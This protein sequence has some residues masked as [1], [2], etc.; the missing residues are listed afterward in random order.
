MV[1]AGPLLPLLQTK[2]CAGLGL[3][4]TK[5]ELDLDFKFGGAFISASDE[6]VK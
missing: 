5:F 1:A 2:K 6:K 4:K 3:P